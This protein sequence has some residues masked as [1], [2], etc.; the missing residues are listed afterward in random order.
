MDPVV[1]THIRRVRAAMGIFLLG[2]AAIIVAGGLSQARQP[3]FDLSTRTSIGIWPLFAC[4]ARSVEHWSGL[5]ARLHASGLVALGLMFGVWGVASV[6]AAVLDAAGRRTTD[7]LLTVASLVLMLSALIM[8]QRFF[9]VAISSRRRS[10]TSAFSLS[11]IH[12]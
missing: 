6:R 5:S 12:I 8:L 9:L 10:S 7:R 11:L 2:F 3:A 1:R 4:T